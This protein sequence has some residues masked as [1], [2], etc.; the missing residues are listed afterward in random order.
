MLPELRHTDSYD[1]AT[2]IYLEALVNEGIDIDH[3][4]DPNFQQFALALSLV[5]QKQGL[6]RPCRRAGF[7]DNYL[8]DLQRDKT[9]N[10]T[11]RRKARQKALRAAKDVFGCIAS[12]RIFDKLVEDKLS[13]SMLTK[14]LSKEFA[15][16]EDVD[17]DLET[18]TISINDVH[19]TD[20]VNEQLKISQANQA[21]ALERLNKF[22]KKDNDG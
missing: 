18:P 11:S 16:D 10:M 6:A 14:I 17:W 4:P 20:D 5:I 1:M 15:N 8:S 22:L 3:D 12:K 13:E 19:I 2:D 21:E 7:Q 9:T